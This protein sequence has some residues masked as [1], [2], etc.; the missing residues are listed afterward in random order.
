VERNAQTA[1]SQKA[2]TGDMRCLNKIRKHFT[3]M[4]TM[5]H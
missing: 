4:F 1:K 3:D 5:P 2:V